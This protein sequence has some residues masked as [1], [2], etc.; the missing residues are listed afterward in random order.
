M[1]IQI[2]AGDLLPGD[3][4]DPDGTLAVV[5]SIG[6]TADRV[7]VAY[8]D[9]DRAEMDPC[10]LVHVDGAMHALVV[11]HWMRE[12]AQEADAW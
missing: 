2:L 8:R 4:V 10:L 7:L 6:H 3:I 1:S 12:V 11:D 9:G 5:D